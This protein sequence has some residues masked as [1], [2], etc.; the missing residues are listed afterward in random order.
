MTV[1]SAQGRHCQDG[2]RALSPDDTGRRADRAERTKSDTG[3]YAGYI[4]VASQPNQPPSAEAAESSAETVTPKSMERGKPCMDAT[5]PAENPTLM[6]MGCDTGAHT[7]RTIVL[8]MLEIF[9]AHAH[10]V[11]TL[12]AR[13]VP[14]IVPVM[15][16][17]AP[18]SRLNATAALAA[19]LAPL[20]VEGLYRRAAHV[21]TVLDTRWAETVP[22]AHH[23]EQ[24]A[25]EIAHCTYAAAFA[26]PIATPTAALPRV[27]STSEKAYLA[28]DCASSVNWPCGTVPKPTTFRAPF[29][30]LVIYDR[31]Q[32]IHATSH[33]Q[34][35]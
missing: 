1:G 7:R 26:E 22:G 19:H 5:V 11:T 34:V 27:G 8:S 16:G 31:R 6:M 29:P 4:H 24:G 25:G 21:L 28:T 3:A 23:G 32:K 15:I 9:R 35:P 14:D 13:P 30:W 18:A 12:K 2:A 20:H 33:V 17:G 10:W